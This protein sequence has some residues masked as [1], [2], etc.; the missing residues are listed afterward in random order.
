MRELLK[1]NSSV[2]ALCMR[3]L[4]LMV[5]LVAGQL[6]TLVRFQAALADVPPIHSIMTYFCAALVFL[7]FPQ[8]ALY[9]S[10]RDRPLTELALRLFMSWSVVLLAGVIFSFLIHHVG[11]LSRLWVLYWLVIGTGMLVACRSAVYIALRKLRAKGRNSRRVVIVGYNQTGREMHRRADQQSWCG[12]QIVGVHAGAIE[13]DSAAPLPSSSLVTN[14]DTLDAI[15]AFVSGHAIDEVWITLPMAAAA[16]VQ[17]L[18][19]L[20]QRVLADVRWIP[21]ILPMQVPHMQMADFLGFPALDLNVPV[22]DGNQGLAKMF[23][24]KLFSAAVLVAIAPLMA[25]IAIGVKCSSPGPVLFKQPRL[26]L[27]GRRFDVYKFRTMAVH[28]EDRGVT[29]ASRDDVRITRF[30]AFLRQR[31]LDE[32][33]QFFNV[34]LGDMSVVG[35]RPHA[36]AHNDHYKELLEQYM[37]RHRVKPGITGWAQINGH[38]GETD[39]IDKMAKRVQFDLY[40]I[41]HWSL[42]MDLRIVLRTVWSGW[43]GENAY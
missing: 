11:E 40:Y 3:L 27:N 17:A 22:S 18:H 36:L 41:Q 43:R 8:L 38:R 1:V 16:E 37:L 5:L 26:G 2:L 25:L 28:R 14:I 42:W 15:P 7:L 9:A 10:W 39:T 19:F 24:D 30:G 4:D 6:A 20:L 12:Y 23:F 35:P 31:S 33:P 29:Q 34:L 13:Q 21:N 32:L